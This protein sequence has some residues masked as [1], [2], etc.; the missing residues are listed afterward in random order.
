MTALSTEG[1]LDMRE[2]TPTETFDDFALMCCRQRH[3]NLLTDPDSFSLTMR[4]GR[5]GPVTLSELVVA[6]DVSI[7]C[8][9]LCNNYRVLV[10]QSGR[11][12]SVH[13][14]VAVPA[15]PGTVA[16]YAPEG[17]GSTRWA[18][19]AELICFK[20]DRCAVD[21]ALSDALGRRCRSSALNSWPGWPSAPRSSTRSYVCWRGTRR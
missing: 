10:L 4:A 7:D 21:D 15:G 12:E 11:T 19:G 16:V 8:G 1:V 5:M 17:A 14:G 9:E 18:A 13:R 20:I 2:W 6:S 3:L